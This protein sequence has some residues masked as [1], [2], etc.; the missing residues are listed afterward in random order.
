MSPTGRSWKRRLPTRTI[1]SF[2]PTPSE[3]PM[4]NFAALL[5]CITLLAGAAQAQSIK[6]LDPALEKV[7]AAGTKIEKIP[8]GFLFIEG[9]MWRDG[10]LWLSDVKGD[11]VRAFDPKT[12]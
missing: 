10:K 5:A 9:P 4:R 7:I 1:P 3:D 6:K 8:T 12:R 11:K 2:S